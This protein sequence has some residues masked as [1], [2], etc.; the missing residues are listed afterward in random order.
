MHRFIHHRERD[1]HCP[2][3]QVRHNERKYGSSKY[4]LAK[5]FTEMPDLLTIFF[6]IKYTTKP[7]HFFGVVGSVLF[8]VGFLCLAYLTI[9]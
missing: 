2:E 9:L 3:C 1:G 7:L 6:L 4:S 5:V 8:A